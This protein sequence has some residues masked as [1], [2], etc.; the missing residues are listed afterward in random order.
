MLYIRLSIACFVILSFIGIMFIKSKMLPLRSSKDFLCI[1]AVALINAVFD[2]ITIYT[3]NHLEEVN[4][5][6]NTFAHIIFLLSINTFIYFLFVYVHYHTTIKKKNN[7]LQTF[8]LALPY[9]I[10]SLLIILLKI[11]YIEAD[12]NYSRGPKAYA[13][14]ASIACYIILICIYEIKYYSNINKTRV[15]SIISSISVFIIIS[16]IQ[17]FIPESLLSLVGIVLIVLSLALSSEN[18]DKYMDSTYN[19]LNVEMFKMVLDDWLKYKKE[20]YVLTISIEDY[21]ITN[22]INDKLKYYQLVKSTIE[23]YKNTY[24]YHIVGNSIIV[25]FTKEAECNKVLSDVEKS[26]RKYNDSEKIPFANLVLRVDGNELNSHQTYKKVTSFLESI[27]DNNANIDLLTNVKNRNA[28]E[29]EYQQFLDNSNEGYIILCDLN[30]VKFINDTK[31]HIAGDQVIKNFAELLR[32]NI[33]KEKGTYRIGG[34]EFV[35]LIECSKEEFEQ[36]IEYL[37]K[38]QNDQN[39]SYNFAFGYASV[40]EDNPFEQADSKMYKNKQK[41]KKHGRILK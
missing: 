30:D 14:Y 40:S 18:I 17:I 11:E 13:L 8:I 5:T 7:A 10:S 35:V 12:I 33:G 3:V 39:N 19:S 38:V 22:K 34:D 29:K 27:E 6:F 28:F 24:T 25:L 31:G 32:N 2:G 16:I 37:T 1:L 15:F 41:M 9:L 23:N 26:L 4:P 21:L 36:N 20:F